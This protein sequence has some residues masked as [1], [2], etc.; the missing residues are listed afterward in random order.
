MEVEG[1]SNSPKRGAFTGDLKHELR[2]PLNHII[3]YC[4]ILL[5]EARDRELSSIIPDLERIH[6]AGRRLLA[7]VNDLFDPNKTVA[8]GIDSNILDHKIRAPLNRIITFTEHLANNPAHPDFASFA[9]DLGKIES[10]AR[11]LLQK[12]VE[13][14]GPERRKP[15]PVIAAKSDS[16]VI[17]ESATAKTRGTEITGLI[18][19]ADD[20][21]T[22][23]EMLGRRL[24]R[25]GHKVEFAEN[26]RRAL[27]LM[28][29]QPFDLVLLDLQMPEIN[30]Y[31]VLAQVK[32]DPSLVH[33]PI[34]VLSASDETS[35]VAQCIEHGA[36]DY[37]PKPFES[38]LLRARIN[39][40][41]EKKRLRD[42]EQ[43]IHKALERSQ[44][45]LAG[46]LAQAAGYIRSLLPS[47]L[48]G[49]ITSE[50]CFQPSA[51]L[52]GDTFGYHW[53]DDDHLA[54][55]LLDV[56]GHG[57]GAALLSVSVVNTVRSQ[58]LPGTDF[59]DPADV[60]ASLNRTFPAANQNFF[61]FTM[62]YGVYQVS[63]RELRFSSG[64]HPPA[65]LLRANGEAIPLTTNGASVGCFDEATY[66]NV[67]VTLESGARLL[68]FSDGAFEIFIAENR[69]RTWDEFL[70]SFLTEETRDRTSKQHLE[71]AQQL[72]GKEA[73]ED[74]FSLLQFHFS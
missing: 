50:W 62:W 25:L 23:R 46:E 37:L 1:M 42:R 66:G 8:Y 35:R 2:T 7:V 9:A 6:M 60:L 21:E 61:Y 26:G 73:L 58:S 44:R 10:A 3:G 53:M 34:I 67:R 69:V 74:D 38:V 55:Y 48:Q 70:A 57:V 45:Q 20:D 29:H 18:L 15:V 49:P 54:I 16:A 28:R 39:A 22:N 52:G 72:R 40:C 68:V 71:H 32:R 30:G 41:L 47:P 4:E 51:A 31:E 33:L 24:A 13:N 14:F 65:L 59:W 43:A 5:D 17:A 11:Q 56:C 12:I 27:D 64:G 36:E 63:Q 19:V